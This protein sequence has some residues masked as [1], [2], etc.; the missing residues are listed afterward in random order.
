MVG[1][2]FTARRYRRVGIRQVV[3]NITDTVVGYIWEPDGKGMGWAY[4]VGPR[5]PKRIPLEEFPS[6]R[7]KTMRAAKAAL[8]G[9]L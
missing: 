9:E 3:Q 7:F 8:V 2:E 4:S 1:A 6:T 5:I